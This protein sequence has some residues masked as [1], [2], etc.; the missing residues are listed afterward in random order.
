MPT[1]GG[2]TLV[3]EKG[4]EDAIPLAISSLTLAVGDMLMLNVGATTWVAATSST[5]HWQR[6]A[7]TI[8]AATSAMTE[9]LCQEVFPGQMWVAEVANTADT[10]HNGDRMVLTDSNTVNNTGTDSAAKEAVFIQSVPV[11]A[12]SDKRVMGRIVWGS[13]VNPDAT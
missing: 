5:A 2:F 4:A 3:T 6:K 9:V 8:Q 12:L 11:G 10:A 1:P 7:V 13:G